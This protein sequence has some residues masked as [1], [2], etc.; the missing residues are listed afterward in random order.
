MQ[1]P[2]WPRKA[3]NNFR[4]RFDFHSLQFQLT[5][6]IAA[7]SI[8][9]ISSVTLGIAWKLDDLI[10]SSHKKQ[11]EQLA[12]R[13]GESVEI[14]SEMMS[15]DEAIERAIA[16]LATEETSIW[17]ARPDGTIARSPSLARGGQDRLLLVADRQATAIPKVFRIREGYW[18]I[19]AGDL[20]VDA[21]TVGKMNIARNITV[22]RQMFRKLLWNLSSVSAIAIG[23]ITI[24]IA[25]Y[26]KKSLQPLQK[27]SQLTASFSAEQL[28]KEQLYL[29]SAPSELHQLENAFNQMLDRFHESWE[30]QREFVSDVSHELRTPL[31]I[32]SGYLQSTLR[33][34]SNLTDPQKEA[35]T[36][37]SS[38]ADRT[39]Q[40]L[41][42]L[43]ELAR[44]DSGHLHFRKEPVLLNDFGSE[45]V[46]MAKQYNPDRAIEF[47]NTSELIE[48]C[49]D[50]NRLKQVL[51]NLI[52]NAVK[53]SPSDRPVTVT[54]SRDKSRGVIQ[55]RDRGPGIPLAQQ[56]RIFE[57]FYRLD[58]AR[59]R[60]TGGTGLGLSIV[61][62]L[63]EGMGGTVSLRSKQGEGSTFIVN[64]RLIDSK[65]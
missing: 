16:Y 59:T 56:T 61:K 47:E 12:E 24:A 13:F 2:Q 4:R 46:E 65:I 34:G 58:E 21:R 7:M 57:R 31:T 37:A 45:V 3:A 39:V 5:V 54:I 43:L 32:V 25:F 51:L 18:T 9:G 28:G 29:D 63:V 42:D 35:L 55:V 49:A 19:C 17:V 22:D 11:V 6:G 53:Y 36:I 50:F 26:I 64:L 8:L 44:A 33:R 60:T 40:L 30:H 48:V 41:E 14:Y 10:I 52:E 62:T 15:V 23:A 38:E 20:Q 1:F 27:L